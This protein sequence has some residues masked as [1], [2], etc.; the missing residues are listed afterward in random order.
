V[1][2]TTSS[3]I[4]SSGKLALRPLAVSGWS[5]ARVIACRLAAL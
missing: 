1:P 2:G 5:A 3:V 4:D